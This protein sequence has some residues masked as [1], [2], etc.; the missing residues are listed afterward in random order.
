MR[1]AASKGLLVF[2]WAWYLLI[3]ALVLLDIQIRWSTADSSG[4]AWESITRTYS[5]FNIIG[6]IV[7][8]VSLSP[9]FGAGWLRERLA[10]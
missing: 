6:W 5:P 7:I 1:S 3:L 8:I 2:M 9:A 4:A 10:R